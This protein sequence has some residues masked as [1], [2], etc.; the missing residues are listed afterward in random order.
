MKRKI[1]CGITAAC[2]LLLVLSGCGG[3][4]PDS[5]KP[6]QGVGVATLSAVGDIAP[7]DS[8][9][10]DARG[11][12]GAY[13]FAP[14]F[15]E[16]F[17]TLAAAD[18][19]VGNLEGTFSGAPY[20]GSEG[21]YPDELAGILSAAGF[22]LLQTA[23][24]YSI[25][26]GLTG[27]QRTKS[28]I[29]QNGMAAVGTYRDGAE[30][31]EQPV[32]IREVNGI[33]FAFVAFTKGFGGLSLPENAAD[34]VNLLY[35]DYTT[36]YSEIDEA[37]ILS[38]L[39]AAKENDPD[40][41]VAMLHWGS[42]N[43]SR[44]SKSQEAITELLLQNDVDVILGAHSHLIGEVERRT[45]SM[46]NGETREAV[47]AYSLG[48]FCTVD[49]NECN[50]SLMLRMEFTRDH[51]TGETSIS[52]VSYTPLAAVDYGAKETDRYRLLNID[53]TM[54]LYESNYY[55][56][57]ST[58]LYHTLMERRESILSRVSPEKTDVE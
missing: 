56:R 7:T 1:L 57:V 17:T 27:L 58:E 10:A 22:D 36:D 6:T 2:L 51:A 35:S 28:I 26:G 31:A 23:N 50:S 55:D 40:V 32:I 41:I 9:L 43:D 16:V 47:I 46:P 15:A 24:S 3:S 4:A 14:Q 52:D 38:T 29:E 53:N 49:K 54:S 25:S 39:Q 34:C 21:S 12:N 8:M 19:T 44:V 37:G 30:K 45:V 48:N 42:E 20:G 18:L 13:D 5:D 11:Q 33:R